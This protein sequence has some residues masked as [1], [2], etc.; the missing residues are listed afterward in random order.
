MAHDVLRFQF[1]QDNIKKIAHSKASLWFVDVGN[2][3]LGLG[4]HM[5]RVA[6]QC[7]QWSYR[8]HGYHQNAIQV[9]VF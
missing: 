6:G 3:G 4:Y 2:D 9:A 7:A 1:M 5:H 8:I